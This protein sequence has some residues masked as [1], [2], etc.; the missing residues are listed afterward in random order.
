MIPLITVLV[1]ILIDLLI[2]RFSLSLTPVVLLDYLLF[3]ARLF[4]IAKDKHLMNTRFNSWVKSRKKTL[5]GR[6]TLWIS[7]YA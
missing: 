3:P 7:K 5:V 4:W 6:L 1:I 2:I